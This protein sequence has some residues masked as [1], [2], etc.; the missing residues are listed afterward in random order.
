[1]PDF[2]QAALQYLTAAEE[3]CPRKN[4]HS[5]VSFAC[6]EERALLAPELRRDVL[7]LTPSVSAVCCYLPGNERTMCGCAVGIDAFPADCDEDAS[8][9]FAVKTEG[10]V[11]KANAEDVIISAHSIGNFS[12][13]RP[14]FAVVLRDTHHLIDLAKADVGAA[15]AVVVD[16]HQFAFLVLGDGWDAIDIACAVV[17]VGQNL[18][19]IKRFALSQ[20]IQGQ[21]QKQDDELCATIFVAAIAATALV[22][23]TQ[24]TV[25]NESRYNQHRGKKDDTLCVHN[26]VNRSC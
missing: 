2:R 23:A 22:I 20:Y 18:H 4:A 3:A 11:A 16:G 9:A 10:W 25:K 1:M 17:A 5:I 26:Q 6:L 8:V 7:R 15:D 24:I 21:K 19:A 12:L 14:F 13:L